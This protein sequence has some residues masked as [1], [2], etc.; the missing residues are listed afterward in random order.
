MRE[1]MR[2]RQGRRRQ[3]LDAD[4]LRHRRL[5]RLLHHSGHEV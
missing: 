1:V 5:Q 3:S 4:A 2:W